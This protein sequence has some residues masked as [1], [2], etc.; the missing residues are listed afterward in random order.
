MHV[1]LFFPTLFILNAI[2]DSKNDFFIKAKHQIGW[3]LNSALG[4]PGSKTHQVIEH[5]YLFAEKLIFWACYY[6]YN[7]YCSIL[8]IYFLLL[9]II[10]CTIM[11]TFILTHL[12]SLCRNFSNCYVHTYVHLRTILLK[13]DLIN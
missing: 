12:V 10:D 4:W 3:F 7:D 11:N 2:L 1:T 6:I 5:E 8:I 13:K 9:C